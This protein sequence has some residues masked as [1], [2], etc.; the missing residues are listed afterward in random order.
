MQSPLSVNVLTSEL[1]RLGVASGDLLM[2]HASLR[3]LGPVDGGAETVVRALEEAVGKNGSLMMNVGARDDVPFHYL[4]TAADPDNGVLA[5]VFRRLPG[6]VLNDH[7]DARFGARGRLAEDLLAV[8]P[9]DDY[10]GPGSALERFVKSGGKVLRLGA[11]LG[12]VTLLHYAEYLVPL[13][14]KR[15][16]KRQH[17][18]VQSNGVVVIRSV[19]CLDDSNGIV[20]YDGQDY[21]E[22]ILQEYLATGRASAGWV[23]HAESEL[24]DGADLVRF[25]V[26]WMHEHLRRD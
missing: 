19:E 13:N 18:L 6:T 5:E 12:T 16:V 1:L 7:P 24:L 3:R 4:E 20:D 25:G 22:V 21:F 14:I 23:G 17:R 9:W 10:Y 11:D 26:S 8:T 2:V 15:R